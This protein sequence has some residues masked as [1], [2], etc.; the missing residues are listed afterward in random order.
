MES[1]SEF[2]CGGP[3]SFFNYIEYELNNNIY[4]VKK[5]IN[6]S[7]YQQH[8][9]NNPNS[10]EIINLKT[11]E[12][13][14]IE[15]FVLPEFG[16]DPSEIS[17]RN[18]GSIFS[19]A[20]SDFKTD[21]IF[22]PQNNDLDLK[23]KELDI[24]DSFTK[25]KQLIVDIY[26]NDQ[27]NNSIR[28]EENPNQ[29][30]D[31]NDFYPTSKIS[32]FKSAFN[33]FFEEIKFKTVEI[34]NDIL[35][36]KNQK[37]VKIDKL[38]TGEKQIVFRGIHL[39]KN[40]S[41]MENSTIFIDEPEL[42]MHPKWQEKIIE[43]FKN[44]F[45]FGSEIKAQLFFATHSDHVLKGAFDNIDENLIIRLNNN[46][47]NIESEIINS[48]SF[49]PIVTLAATKYFAYNL[50]T[51]DFHIELFSFIQDKINK[52]KIKDCDTYIANH[53]FFNS[54]IHSKISSNGTVNYQ[55]LPT[56]IRNKI[57]HPTDNLNN[58]SDDELKT[59]T[60]LLLEICKSF[61]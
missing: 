43:Y 22:G 11:G 52:P 4:Q 2:L 37:D 50:C 38:S 14:L 5:P 21:N 58:F 1:L 55:T 61:P 41:L 40:K 7:G 48:P 8:L 32:R 17:L 42:S 56:L 51:N 10:F 35:F 29:K 23:K 15:G 27:R 26:V 53:P 19:K 54:A 47:G 60:E 36:S 3:F 12:N 39:L 57:H 31:W 25:L 16:N 49:F 34:N 9:A 46:S 44:L 6:L 28:M 30:T 59:S 24:D 18:Y 13:S 20:R 45:R 33:S